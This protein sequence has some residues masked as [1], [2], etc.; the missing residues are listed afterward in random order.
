MGGPFPKSPK[1]PS[2]SDQWS[3]WL[4]HVRSFYLQSSVPVHSSNGFACPTFHLKKFDN[5]QYVKVSIFNEDLYPLFD[6]GATDSIV[7]TGGHS[8]LD[9]FNIPIQGHTEQTIS[10]ADGQVQRIVDSVEIPVCLGNVCN[11][12]KFWV[13]PFIL[14]FSG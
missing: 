9:R 10:T 13:V 5:Q 11:L 1:S 4:S 2:H 8:F 14:S 12:I 3:S 7:G 6:T